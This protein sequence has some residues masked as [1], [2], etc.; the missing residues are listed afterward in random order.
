MLAVVYFSC[1]LLLLTVVSKQNL[2]ECL[3]LYAHYFVHL[4]IK[5]DNGSCFSSFPLQFYPN[6]RIFSILSLKIICENCYCGF[7]INV[8]A[9]VLYSAFQTGTGD[10]FNLLNNRKLKQET[11][12]DLYIIPVKF[13][14]LLHIKK[15][16]HM[17]VNACKS[18]KVFIMQS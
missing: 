9:N 2:N 7:N 4:N 3:W 15:Y 14:C 10:C 17:K 12:Y 8:Y 6:K 5:A 13:V 16:I 11:F 1:L 18:L